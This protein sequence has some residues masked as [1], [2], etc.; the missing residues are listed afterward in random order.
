MTTTE[1]RPTV[2]TVP[3]RSPRTTRRIRIAR[4]ST[5]AAVTGLVAWKVIAQITAAGTGAEG[6]CPFGGFETAWTWLTTGR[7]VSHVHPA[8]LTLAAAITVMALVGRGFFCGWLCPLG[9]IQGAI[10]TVTAAIIDR[11]PPL[12]RLRRRITRV[13]SRPGGPGRRLDSLLRYGRWLVLG[14]ALIGAGL[15]GVMVF[16]EYDPW[17]ALIA[18]ADFE[19]SLA[20]MVL[21]AVLLLSMVIKRPFC[22]YACPL[23]AISGLT[24]K[25]SPVA[26]ERH[27]ESCLGCDLCNQACPVNI[28]VNQRTRVTDT[29]CL[30]CLECVAACPSRDALDISLALPR[31]AGRIRTDKPAPDLVSAER[32]P[33][34]RLPRS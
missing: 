10:H 18:I 1:D 12:R 8:N 32:M 20:F 15:T 21:V 27:A 4:Y 19:V 33:A 17:A 25:L 24:A 23:G 31:P 6:L 16:R 30:G 5:Q 26:I 22:R 11:I 3:R 2:V 13:V 28:P 9:A 14:W 29:S 34:D 7:T